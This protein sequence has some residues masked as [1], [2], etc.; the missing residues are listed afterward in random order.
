MVK[1]SIIKQVLKDA[2]RAI[3]LGYLSSRHDRFGEFHDTSCIC[4]PFYGNKANI[5]MDEHTNIGEN[6]TFLNLHGRFFMK[7][8][9]TSGPHLTVVTANHDYFKVGQYPGSPDWMK[10]TLPVE[11]IRVDD[12]VWLGA[13][14]TLLPG[15]HI[16]RGCIVAAGSVCVKGKLPLYS[17]IGGN[18]AKFI[19]FRLTLEEQLEQERTI[20]PPDERIPEEILIQNWEK[21]QSLQNR[22]K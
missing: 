3:K 11:D 21:Y 2:W 17:I 4:M 16:P 9:S 7:K 5:F 15:V 8:Y 13:N 19:K 12:Y 10:P 1:L 14:V 22:K 18:P 6:S 20:V